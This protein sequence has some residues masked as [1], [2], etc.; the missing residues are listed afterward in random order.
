MFD[1]MQKK[2][3][4]NGKYHRGKYNKIYS[5]TISVSQ[6]VDSELNGSHVNCV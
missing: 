2:K 3:I 6:R 4:P 1:S 5:I